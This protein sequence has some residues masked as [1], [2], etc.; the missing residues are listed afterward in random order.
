MMS[1]HRFKINMATD[2]KC[3]CVLYRDALSTYYAQL[4]IAFESVYYCSN[5]TETKRNQLQAYKIAR[6]LIKAY[7]INKLQQ[8]KQ[9]SINIQKKKK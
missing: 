1:C 4:V 7:K 6:K 9:F 5:S 3:Y 8:G 2:R